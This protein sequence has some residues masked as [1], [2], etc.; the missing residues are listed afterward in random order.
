MLGQARAR[1]LEV[2][3]AA[4]VPRR[5]SCVPVSTWLLRELVLTA[6]KSYRSS[7]R[8]SSKF[9]GSVILSAVLSVVL[10]DSTPRRRLKSR[11]SRCRQPEIGKKGQ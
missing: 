7:K 3:Q 11:L 1:Q 10:T 4:Q 9:S 8:S 5:C 6:Q 2:V